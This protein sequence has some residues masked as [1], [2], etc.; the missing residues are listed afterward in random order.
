MGKR[1]IKQQVNKLW[2]EGRNPIRLFGNIYLVRY[3]PA[4]YMK[5]PLYVIKILK[6]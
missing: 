5:F 1:T 3:E 6:E 2:A 4:Y